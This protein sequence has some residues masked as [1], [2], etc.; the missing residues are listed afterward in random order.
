MRHSYRSR[1]V[2]L[3]CACVLMLL[4]SAPQ[5]AAAC[6]DTQAHA[7]RWCVSC[8][9]RAAPSQGKTAATHHRVAAVL[10]HTPFVMFLYTCCWEYDDN[11][12]TRS[13]KRRADE[14]GSLFCQSDVS[15]T[16]KN[17]AH[18]SHR[19]SVSNP[20]SLSSTHTQPLILQSHQHLCTQTHRPPSPVPTSR[21][22]CRLSS[23][24]LQGC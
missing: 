4:L 7:G 14:R 8:C 3:L 9:A 11:D 20:S 6:A 24:E 16:A 19:N 10:R 5:T 23:M 13:I 15:V 2:R 1:G 18:A 12:A 21:G 22:T 17:D